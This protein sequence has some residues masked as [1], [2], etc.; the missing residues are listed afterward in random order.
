MRALA[1]ALAAVAL[2]SGVAAAGPAAPGFRVRLLDSGKTVDSRDLIG[3]KILVLR[4]QASYCKPCARESAALARLA[5]RYRA[6]NVELLVIHVQDTA[7]DARAFLRANK[8]SYPVALDPRLTIGNRF[9]FRGT[10]YTVVVDRKGEIA[11]RLVGES[12]TTKLPRILDDLLRS[13]G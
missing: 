3:K 2:L 6:R 5:D 8:A 13:Q 7:A 12:A 1:L 9:G 10:P 4:F 11:A